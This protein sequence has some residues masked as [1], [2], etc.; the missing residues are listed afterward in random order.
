MKFNKLI[1]E[2]SVSTIQNSL[3]FYMDI[4]GFTLEYQREESKFAMISLEGNQLMI[5]E[6]N[7]TWGVGLLEHPFGRGIN[8][9]M[10][11]QGVHTF[12]R[13]VKDSRYPIF[14]DIKDNWYRQENCLV[15]NREFLIQDPDGYMLRFAEY[16]GTKPVE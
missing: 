5:E 4:L 16:L 9:Q 7:E 10:Y 3:E 13:R 11:V 1:P 6:I 15:G 2:L 12:Y 14:A 8:L